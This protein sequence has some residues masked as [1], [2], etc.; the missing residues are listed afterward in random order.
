M[1]FKDDVKAREQHNSVRNNVGWYRWSHDLLEVRGTDALK[2]L[3][4]LYVNSI[5]KADVGRSKYTTMLNEK[6]EIIDDVIVTHMGE[7]HYWVS[8]LY[9]PRLKPWIDAHKGNMDITYKEL[10]YEVDMYAVQGP[11][12]LKM[13]NAM[14][15]KH[16]DEMKRFQMEDNRI[17][18]LDV[19]I[20]RSGFTGELGY[21]IYCATSETK[22][23]ADAIREAGKA[24][25]AM[26][27]NIL[28]VY[29]RSLSMEKG[30]AL[31]QDMYGLNPFECDLGWS[32]DLSKDFIGKE[33]TLRCKEEGPK[34]KLVGLEFEAE[35]YEDTNQSDPVRYLGVPVGQ[36]RYAIYGYT[37]NKN[38][39]FAIVDAKIPMGAR[40]TIGQND[41]PAIVTEK[42]WI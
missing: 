2:C 9:A 4:Y 31:C 10:T 18:N 24:F 16:I 27:L 35:S 3:D 6:G 26:E 12:S 32:V 40:I 21:E 34:R 8:T 28:E 15:N 39:G 38:I 42:C 29:V 5:G 7:N 19:K 33:A 1:L 11:N 22:A 17:G 20:H 14:L 41:T 25:D 37:V 30:F 13:M 36:F 23:V